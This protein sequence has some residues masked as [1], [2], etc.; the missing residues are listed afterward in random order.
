MEFSDPRFEYLSEYVL[1][2]MKLKNDKWAKMQGNEEYRQKILEFFEKPELDLLVIMQNSGGQLQPLYDFPPS[3][4]TKAVYFAKKEKSINIGKDVVKSAL[5]CGDLSY[6]PLE[7]LSVLVEEVC[8]LLFLV[9]LHICLQN[10]YVIV[11]L[12]TWAALRLVGKR[13]VI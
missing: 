5:A 10:K 12:A 8:S 11:K 6:T 4:K 3:L 7:Q 2:T 13:I 9:E 1:K